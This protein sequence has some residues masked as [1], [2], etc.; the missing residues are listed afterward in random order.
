MGDVRI[1]LDRAAINRLLHGS[2]ARDARH[3]AAERVKVK[4]EENIH[5]RSGETALLLSI[6]DGGAAPGGADSRT[7]IQT[8]EAG[9]EAHQDVNL[10]AWK[11]LEYG[12]SKMQAQAPGRKAL[13]EAAAG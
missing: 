1:E 2:G 4:W 11:W 5:S 6:S 12:T 8:G 3:K 10:S 9:P 13:G 7:Y